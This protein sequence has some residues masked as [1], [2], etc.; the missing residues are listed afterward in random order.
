LTLILERCG[1][2]TDERWKNAGAGQI[3]SRHCSIST[4]TYLW[5]KT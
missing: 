5:K 1:C 3:L 2:R 4:F